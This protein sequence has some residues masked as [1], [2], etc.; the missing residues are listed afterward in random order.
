M[1]IRFF[2]SP[3]ECRKWLEWNHDKQSELWFGFYKKSSGKKGI[4][5]K[6]ALDEA[7]C[8]GWIDG[9]KHR[10]D[11]NSYALRFSPRR[12]NSIWSNINTKRAEE[13]RELGRMAP[14]GLKMFAARDPKRSG[15]YSFE[16]RPKTFSADL[17]KRFKANKGAWKLFQAM[18]P[19]YQRLATFYVMN[20]K[21]EETRLKRL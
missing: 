11:E 17:E 2:K 20:A 19:G 15:I 18:P 6:E 1:K 3:G 10:V 7:L 21:K 4:T 12:P 13:L 14:L 16:N 5:Y 8:F 9:L